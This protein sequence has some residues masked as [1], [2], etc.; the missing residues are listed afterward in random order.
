MLKSFRLTA[1]AAAIG[2][3]GSAAAQTLHRIDETF[4]RADFERAG[5]RFVSSSDALR[6][7]ADDRTRNVFDPAIRGKTDRFALVFEKPAS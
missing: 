4:A 3:A 6:N 7:G 5:F 1:I 2:F